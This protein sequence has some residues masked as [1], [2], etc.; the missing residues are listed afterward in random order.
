[1]NPDTLLVMR[2]LTEAAPIFYIALGLLGVMLLFRYLMIQE[3]RLRDER[4]T[5]SNP[6]ITISNSAPAS[7]TEREGGFQFFEVNELQKRAF[8]DAFN[9]FKEYAEVRGYAVDVYVDASRPGMVGLKIT[10]RDAGVTVS[11]GQVRADVN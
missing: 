8:I 10:V 5:R 4:L 3:R 11:T 7:E 9:G 2:V 6:T 1:M